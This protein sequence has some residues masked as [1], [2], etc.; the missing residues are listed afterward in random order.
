MK[1]LITFGCS[2][3]YGQGLP[4]CHVDPHYPGLTPSKFAWPEIVAEGLNRKCIN[5]STPGSSNKRIWY[6]IINFKFKPDDIVIVLWSW[7]E[8]F[9]ILKDKNSVNDI[10]TWM[11]SE[12]AKAY[13]QHLYN[14]YDSLMQTK[15]YVSHANF[16]LKDKAIPV[17]NLTVKKETTD[18]FKLSGQRVSHIPLY[19]CDDNYV[20]KYPP[21]LDGKHPG[22]ECNRIF[23][24]DMLYYI[25]PDS[26]KTFNNLIEKIRCIL[27]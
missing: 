8:R 9:A 3:T 7:G 17:Y 21:A 22:V 18:I 14:E 16:I 12:N 20:S 25:M 5:T 11:E 1:R 4:D 26:K 6:N 19:I 23:A 27:T 24:K 15:L 10:G 2:L 13:Y